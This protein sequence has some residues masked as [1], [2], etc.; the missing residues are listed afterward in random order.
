MTV[1]LQT[2]LYPNDRLFRKRMRT[3]PTSAKTFLSARARRVWSMRRRAFDALL[4]RMKKIICADVSRALSVR[5][6]KIK[7]DYD[8]LLPT[9]RRTSSW[10]T[11][12]K[13]IFMTMAREEVQTSRKEGAGNE[14]AAQQGEARNVKVFRS[15]SEL[16][17]R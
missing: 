16:I 7:K 17:L 4:G 15:Q 10:T 8:S 3:S 12:D 6:K 9:A 2:S 14:E 13:I 1:H 11:S 5:M